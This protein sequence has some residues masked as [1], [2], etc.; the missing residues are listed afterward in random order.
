MRFRAASPSSSFLQSQRRYVRR[1][2][3]F[4]ERLCFC[5][6]LQAEQA[7]GL[8]SLRQQVVRVE[9][10]QFI[11]VRQGQ[12]IQSQ[13]SIAHRDHEQQLFVLRFLRFHLHQIGEFLLVLFQL[14]VDR[15]MPRKTS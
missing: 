15:A 3:C 14:I 4:E 5:V 13:A 1:E 2:E 7:Q 6:T 11:E 10:L 12:V 8:S 9:I